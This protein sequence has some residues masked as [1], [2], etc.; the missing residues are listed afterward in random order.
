LKPCHFWQPIP[1]VIPTAVGALATQ[2][3]NLLFVRTIVDLDLILI[4]LVPHEVADLGATLLNTIVAHNPPV[5]CA[6]INNGTSTGLIPANVSD[7]ARAIVTAGFA[8]DVDAVN[9]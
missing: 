5:T 7:N 6:A 2:G 1:L 9:Q 8:K 3:R 4:L